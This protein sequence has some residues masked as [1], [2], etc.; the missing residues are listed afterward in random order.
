MLLASVAV[1]CYCGAERSVYQ[2]D[3]SHYWNMSRRWTSLERS[4][5]R[6]ALRELRDSV[7]T[8][9]Y[10][11]LAAVPVGTW[12]AMLGQSR[13]SYLLGI[14][15]IYVSA[16]LITF[17]AASR[18][19][20]GERETRHGRWID[21]IPIGVMLLA[22]SFWVPVV[23]GYVDVGGM[24]FA[25]AVLWLYFRSTQ[26]PALHAAYFGIGALLAGLYL[27]RRWYAY[28]I[29]SFLAVAA[30]DRMVLLCRDCY[31]NGFGIRRVVRALAPIAVMGGTM[32]LILVS[33]AW[34]LLR[35]VLATDYADIYSAY[36]QERGILQNL[37]RLHDWLGEAA[38]AF[39]LVAGIGLVTWRETRRMSVFL[40][41]QASLICHLFSRVQYFGL[42]HVYLILPGFFLVVTVFTTKVAISLPQR[43]LRGA[44]LGLLLALGLVTAVPV[45][46]RSARPIAERLGRLAPKWSF[47]PLVR[48]DVPELIRM[49]SVLDGYLQ[50][51]DDRV[52]TLAASD[53]FSSDVL[54][55][56]PTSLV[57][58]FRSVDR[59]ITNCPIVD[60]RDGFP[61]ELLKARFVMVA[62]PAQYHLR[63]SDEQVV[64]IPAESFLQGTGIGRAFERLPESFSLE[65]GARVY[66]FRKTRPIEPA[67]IAEL[68]GQL[69]ASYPD[70]PFIYQP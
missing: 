8:E 14:V 58:P 54:I 69:R 59:V 3:Y 53:L 5:I 65:N 40:F 9:D 36:N 66:M 63:P 64:G 17:L 31:E 15:N 70:R 52:Y 67:E 50:G 25:L 1:A 24:A 4:S 61:K 11:L 19:F 43:W 46:H 57:V 39:G 32:G 42:H 37:L 23:R 16:V 41:A 28:W 20:R 47:Y 21:F 22:P 13:V 38:L 2:W 30:V 62:S 10:N 55:N 6:Q 7:A 51:P 18:C 34:P 60:K 29:V 33:V 56:A 12:M 35:R 44:W 45:F 48:H 49:M 68:S 27:F 26:R